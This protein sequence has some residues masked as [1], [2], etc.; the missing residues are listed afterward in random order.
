MSPKILVYGYNGWIGSHFANLPN[1]FEGK[2]RIDN[3]SEVLSE[4]LEQNPTHIVL[5]TGKYYDRIIP[6]CDY[7][8]LPGKL[9]ENIT[10]N[11]VGPVFISMIC[12]DYDIHLT[13]ITDAEIYGGG[14]GEHTE[15]SELNHGDSQHKTIISFTNKLLQINE[16][17]LIIR[18]SMPINNTDNPKNNLMK[19]LSFDMITNNNFSVRVL[20]SLMSCIKCL[21]ENEIVGI[22]NVANPGFI[23]HYEIIKLYHDIT[24]NTIKNQRIITLKQL[25]DVVISERCLPRLDCSK[26]LENFPE[27]PDVHDALKKLFKSMPRYLK[28]K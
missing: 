10:N 26:L 16:N 27:I 14:S 3:Y 23:S 17:A 4:I 7:L 28:K 13:Y 11:L 5:A 19:L 22:F 9:S 18:L 2:S 25:N 6:N 24:N 8:E 15:K 12:L 1:Y 21:I 20:P